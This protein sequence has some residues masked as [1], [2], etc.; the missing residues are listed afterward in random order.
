MLSLHGLD[1]LRKSY[2]SQ[3][4]SLLKRAFKFG[5]VK[6]IFTIEELLENYDDTVY[7]KIIASNHI[8]R[9]LLPTPESHA[10]A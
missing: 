5:Y 9:H 1:F 10:M 8:M 3:I 2:V 4:N 6:F 7:S